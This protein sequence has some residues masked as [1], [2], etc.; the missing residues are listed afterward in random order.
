MLGWC[1]FAFPDYSAL[2]AYLKALFN[3]GAGFL[4][5]TSAAWCLGY[6]PLLIVC[7]FASL[8]TAKRLFARCERF[9]WFGAV[10]LAGLLLLFALCITELVSQS[11]NPF[12]YFRF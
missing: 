11:Y 4:S 6:V 8:P 1:I 9:R 12:I 7:A 5:D 3:F 2:T 10:R